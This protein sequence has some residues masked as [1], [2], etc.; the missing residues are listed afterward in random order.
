MK[1][2]HLY[3][4]ECKCPMRMSPVKLHLDGVKVVIPILEGPTEGVIS[5][6]IIPLGADWNHI[7]FLP[8]ASDVRAKYRIVTDDG[9]NIDLF[10]DG[11]MHIAW[12]KVPNALKRFSFTL[13]DY[14]YFREHLYFK[15]SDERY[16]WLNGKPC[17]AVLGMKVRPPY[18][19]ICY[20]A[21]MIEEL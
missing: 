12:N 16:A 13:S 5:G 9:A 1:T 8:V 4:T 19:L 21:Y 15:T 18:M 14:L 10:T 2:K 7:Q 20:N 11:R 17:Y 6:K 3:Y